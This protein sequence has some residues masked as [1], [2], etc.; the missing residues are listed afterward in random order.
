M[1]VDFKSQNI[2]V[3]ANSKKKNIR[4]FNSYSKAF[5]QALK[6]D[7]DGD[8]DQDAFGQNETH[9]SMDSTSLG[10]TV[11]RPIQEILPK[12]LLRK[13]ANIN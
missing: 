12:D 11:P 3:N 1:E 6:Q 5:I 13:V 2:V 7:A 8:H 4:D 10:S 9:I